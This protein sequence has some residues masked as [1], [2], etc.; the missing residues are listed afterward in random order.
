MAFFEEFSKKAQLYAEVAMEKTKDLAEVV[1]DRAK[2]ATELAKINMAILGEQREIEKSY[3]VIGEWFVAEYTEEIPDAL[4][5]VMAAVAASKERIAELED[6][7]DA[8]RGVEEEEEEVVVAVEGK[9]CP[10]CGLVTSGKYCPE[11]GTKLGE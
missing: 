3:K 7:R 10:N 2:A 11:C 5:D 4:K 1:G 9:L 8:L 6:A